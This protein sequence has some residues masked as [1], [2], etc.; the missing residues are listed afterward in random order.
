MLFTPMTRRAMSLAYDAHHGQTDRAGVPYIL[1]PA[2]VAA[3]FTSEAEACAAWLHDVIEDTCVTLEDIRLAGFGA[4]ICDALQLMTHDKSVPY[5]DYV[6]RI[7]ENPIARAVKLADLRDNMD[8]S[9]LPGI[10]AAAE[11]R[12][13]KYRAAYDFLSSVGDGQT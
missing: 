1:H 8:L 12:L 13:E 9:R 3:G 10:D 2:R 6:G 5:M 4:A 11:A 7:A